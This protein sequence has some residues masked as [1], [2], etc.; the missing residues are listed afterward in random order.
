M[1][2]TD[3]VAQD[4]HDTLLGILLDKIQELKL[5]L[6]EYDEFVGSPDDAREL[7]TSLRDIESK[8]SKYENIGSLSYFAQLSESTKPTP[9]R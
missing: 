1:N 6:E 7:N 8:L 2:E 5:E 9:K 4:R 3:E